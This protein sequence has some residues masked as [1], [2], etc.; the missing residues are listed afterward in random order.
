MLVPHVPVAIVNMHILVISVSAFNFE[1]V[2]E[3][4]CAY[5]RWALMHRFLS[6]T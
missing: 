1:V 5:A 3:P 2:F 6:V 4:T